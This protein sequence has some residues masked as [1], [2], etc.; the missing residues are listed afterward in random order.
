MNKHF[1]S[2][3][4][5]VQL[6]LLSLFS[7]I[8]AYCG[9]FY[10][11]PTG[12]DENEGSVDN[13]WRSL[14]YSFNQLVPGDTLYLREG[15][16]GESLRMLAGGEENSV[17]TIRNYK[18]ERPVIDGSSTDA[19][20]G[21]VISTAHLELLGLEI[22][23]WPDS[24]IWVES[25]QDITIYNCTVH[26]VS[27]G[28][29]FAIGSHNFTLRN[30]YMYS[31]DLYGFDASPSGGE[32]CYDGT[33]VNCVAGSGRD[34]EQ[35]VDGF[36]LGHGDQHGFRLINCAAFDVADGF[37]IS[38]DQTT[39]VGCIASNCYTAGYKIWGDDVTLMN[40]IGY[41]GEISNLELD[42]SGTPKT[43][44][45]IN[46]DIIDA[47]IF[48]IWV[49]DPRDTLILYNSIVVGGKNIGIAF[50]SGLDKGYVGD[51]NLFQNDD[52]AR[53]IV[54]G[55]E[56]EYSVEDVSNGDWMRFS[57]QDSH[58][59]VT[60]NVNGLFMDAANMDFSPAEKSTIIDHGG[61]QYQVL[62]DYD[63]LSRPHGEGIDIGAY[64]Y[65]ENR[66]VTRN[67]PKVEIPVSD[68]SNAEN[69]QNEDS[70]TEENNYVAV[71]FA[72]LILL[73]I[74]V[75]IVRRR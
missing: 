20:N 26:D 52:Q 66:P 43:V 47:E 9:E 42:W 18:G 25:S 4:I 35:N 65:Y 64:E 32:D 75:I 36:A 51:Y 39:L 33:I 38:A 1:V 59:V 71:F 37:D 11:S 7:I 72:V 63:G 6:C 19:Q 40:C 61:D 46:C 24:G 17:I 58:T 62:F 28:I 15:V 21:V 29:G 10:V 53:M 55:Y 69:H 57:G 30:C 31:F 70:F 67:L 5:L 13:P 49:E 2:R 73:A 34:P 60:D 27:C 48:N 14:E 45:V 50:E 68:H 44:T 3:F 56:E 74:A 41:N 12:S 8:G 54:I 22:R 23:N 16:Y